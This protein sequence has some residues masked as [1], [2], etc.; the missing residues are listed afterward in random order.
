[1]TTTI[2]VADDIPDRWKFYAENR[3]HVVHFGAV[4]YGFICVFVCMC[5]Q[6]YVKFCANFNFHMNFE[7]RHK[8]L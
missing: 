1:V 3:M 8:Y 6:K 4:V 2:H 5:V 7:Y